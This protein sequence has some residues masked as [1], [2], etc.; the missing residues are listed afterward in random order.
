VKEALAA[1]SSAQGGVGRTAVPD[2]EPAVLP[3]LT[4]YPGLCV[5]CGTSV[6]APA[7]VIGDQWW[8]NPCLMATREG[9]EHP[10]KSWS[11]SVAGLFEQ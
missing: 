5:D 6:D 2:L 3:T 1:S 10:F 4:P 11:E 8:C 7:L 9:L